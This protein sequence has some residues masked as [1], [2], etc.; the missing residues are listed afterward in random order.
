MQMIVIAIALPARP[1]T[2]GF[3]IHAGRRDSARRACRLSLGVTSARVVSC[4][5]LA[6]GVHTFLAEQMS[7]LVGAEHECEPDDALHQPDGGGG[8]P[9]PVLD[10]VVIDPGV[11]HF[12]R[13][14]ADVVALQHDLLESHGEDA[15]EVQDEQQDDHGHDP[16]NRDRAHALP[17]AGS[18]DR[19]SLVQ[20]LIDV[21]QCREEDDRAPSRVLPGRL[22]RNQE[23][24]EPRGRHRLERLHPECFHE[25]RHDAGGAEHL[26]EDRDDDDPAQEVRKVDDTLHELADPSRHD[27][28]QQ[29]REDDRDREEEHELEAGDHEGVAQRLPERRIPEDL[30][31]VVEPDPHAVDEAEVGLVVLERDDVA[32]Q[33]QPVEDHEVEEARRDQ[34]QHHAVA[35]DARPQRALA[36]RG[37]AVD[38]GSPATGLRCAPGLRPRVLRGSRRALHERLAVS[39]HLRPRPATGNIFVLRKS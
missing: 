2:V 14:G 21:H 38:G 24:E 16:G 18:V 9:L 3:S 22:D 39:A 10:A 26:A 36:M 29:Q 20:L 32:R 28:V 6:T 4:R 5:S 19:R 12:A 13:T 25:M 23:G 15:A 7:D 11:E 30:H 8:T 1:S 27:A 37:D 31:E 17:W 33:R 34:Q 35:L